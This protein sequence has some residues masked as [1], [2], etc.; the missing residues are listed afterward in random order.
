[1]FKL[2]L[3]FQPLDLTKTKVL[4]LSLESFVVRACVSL[5]ILENFDL[6][7]ISERHGSG[8]SSNNSTAG[9]YKPIKKGNKCH[10]FRK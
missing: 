9:S 5:K 7:I 3:Y 2:G 6:N 4:N 8:N 1:M 10:L